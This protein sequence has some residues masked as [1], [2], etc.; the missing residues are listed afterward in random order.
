MLKNNNNNSRSKSSSNSYSLFLFIPLLLFL[1]IIFYYAFG[2][3]VKPPTLPPI[4]NYYFSQDP[5]MLK[6]RY[7]CGCFPNSSKVFLEQDKTVEISEIK[8]GDK[9]LSYDP[10]KNEY[11]YSPVVLIPHKK[12]E[13]KQLFLKITL[14]S[15]KSITMTPTHYIPIYNN[16]NNIITKKACDLKVGD[17]LNYCN[18]SN[19]L[20]SPF[21]ISIEKIEEIYDNG[22]CTVITE[23]EYIVVDNIVVSSF[24]GY[25]SH[26]L[27]NIVCCI[28]RYLYYIHPEINNSNIVNKT[29]EN[30]C[31]LYIRLSS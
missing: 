10:K 22:L 7:G 14:D 27:Q 4:K 25:V 26:S 5:T 11:I 8:V 29:V 12:T 1:F 24:A 2:Q 20:I 23:Y 18:L 28:F 15:G 16:M 19:T 30:V 21:F 31:N 3:N 6:N 17:I 9:I 13:E